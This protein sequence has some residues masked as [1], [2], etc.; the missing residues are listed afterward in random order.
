VYDSLGNYPGDI[1]PG[2][3]VI[4][5][6]GSRIIGSGAGRESSDVTAGVLNPRGGRRFRSQAKG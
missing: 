1:G 3:L 5:E 4:S 2:Q 6:D